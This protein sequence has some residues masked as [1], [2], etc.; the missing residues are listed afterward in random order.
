MRE[1]MFSDSSGIPL[2]ILLGDFDK[3][4]SSVLG[5]CKRNAAC[6][7]GQ[8]RRAPAP[9]DIANTAIRDTTLCA[10][11]IQDSESLAALPANSLAGVIIAV[12][13]LTLRAQ[14]SGRKVEESGGASLARV[15]AGITNFAV[16]P[17]AKSIFPVHLSVEPRRIYRRGVRYRGVSHCGIRGLIKA[18]IQEEENRRKDD[19]S[20]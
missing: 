17:A 18:F 4:T 7:A 15:C 14:P 16:F 11:S 8:T 13:K 1:H 3:L 12:C 20:L 6:E 2:L 19:S 5:C 9:I 10:S